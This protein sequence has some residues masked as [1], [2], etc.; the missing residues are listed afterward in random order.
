MTSP[1]EDEAGPAQEAFSAPPPTYRKAE[2]PVLTATASAE[3]ALAAIVLSG[4]S[5]LRGNEACVL[6]ASD[7]EGVHQMRVAVRRLRSSLALFRDFLSSEQVDHLDGE[8]RWLIGELGPARDWDVFLAE[9]LSKVVAQV[10]NEAGIENLHVRARKKQEDAYRRA[11]EALRSQRY[12]GMVMLLGAWAEG[13]RW[14]DPAASAPAIPGGLQSPAETVAHALLDTLYRRVRQ[15]GRRFASLDSAGRHKLR[16]QIKK[17]RYAIEFFG[18]L[19]PKERLSVFL[20]DAK[21]LQ[22]ALG[23]S[24]DIDVA[25][26]L[27]REIIKGQRGKERARLSFAAGLVIGWHGHV[28]DDREQT[29]RRMWRRFI[30]RKPFWVEPSEMRAAGEAPVLPVAIAKPLRPGAHGG[31]SVAGGGTRVQRRRRPVLVSS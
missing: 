13:R 27:V 19:Y 21:L 11:Q 23:V 9:T 31:R 14:H 20:A 12:L 6:A 26:R 3:D 22:D 28:A 30:R 8:L 18:S 2:V 16:I 7:E 15:V 25:R 4:V 1:S 10:R 24:N 5:H 29:L 17:L